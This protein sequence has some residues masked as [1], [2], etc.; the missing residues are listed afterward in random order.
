MWLP[1]VI[2]IAICDDEQWQN[3][4]LILFYNIINQTHHTAVVM[5]ISFRMTSL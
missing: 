3:Y 1:N 4:I 5:L 2:F